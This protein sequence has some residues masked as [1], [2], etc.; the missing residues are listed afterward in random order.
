MIFTLPD[1]RLAHIQPWNVCRGAESAE[2]PANTR[3]YVALTKEDGF[4]TGLSDCGEW[5]GI[6][7]A[8]YPGML[9][10]RSAEDVLEKLERL[11]GQRKKRQ[12]IHYP[13]Y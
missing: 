9:Y 4:T 13:L 11:Y 5:V 2:F 10:G 12:L 3:V 7:G 1:G 8:G 6:T